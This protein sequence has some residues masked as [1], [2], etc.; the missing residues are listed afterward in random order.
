M[1]EK[2]KI[3]VLNPGQV[4]SFKR[5]RRGPVTDHAN[6]HTTTDSL[7]TRHNRPISAPRT[8][9]SILEGVDLGISTMVAKRKI[10]KN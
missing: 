3:V 6:T 8:K 10:K 7:I 4:T 9:L 2:Q 1:P 5:R